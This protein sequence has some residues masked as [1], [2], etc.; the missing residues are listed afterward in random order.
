MLEHVLEKRHE[1]IE[2]VTLDNLTN[3]QLAATD[4]A[5]FFQVHRPPVMVDEVQYAPEL[6][7][8]IKMMVD[9]GRLPALSGSRARSSSSLWNWPAN[10]LRAARPFSLSH[11]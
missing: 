1:P 8:E 7:S 10:R 3:R 9:R 4:P 2:V 11:R 5:M 6:F